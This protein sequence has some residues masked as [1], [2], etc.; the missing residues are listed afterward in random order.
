MR[1]STPERTYDS[2]FDRAFQPGFEEP[3]PFAASSGSD[4]I[5]TDAASLFD[6]S[7]LTGDEGASEGR[8]AGFLRPRRLVDGFVVALWVVGAALVVG[9]IVVLTALNEAIYSS[10]G[11]TQ[12]YPML[13]MMFQ[14][15]PWLTLLGLATLIGTVFLLATRWD[16]RS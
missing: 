5:D 3:D 11:F 6:D 9:G 1:D 12:N 16:A 15:S 14:L 2:R 8:G 7:G 10:S 4:Q 13:M